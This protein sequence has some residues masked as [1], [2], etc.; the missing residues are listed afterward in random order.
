MTDVLDWGLVVW[1]DGV[2]VAGET[3]YMYQTPALNHEAG[4]EVNLILSHDP[5]HQPD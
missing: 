3:F 5:I 4:R 2:F 1:V